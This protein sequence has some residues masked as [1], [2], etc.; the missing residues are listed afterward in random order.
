MSIYLKRH[1]KI[2]KRILHCIRHKINLYDVIECARCYE[3]P[4]NE[5][6]NARFSYCS[7]PLEICFPFREFFL[8][9]EIYR[10][11]KNILELTPPWVRVFSL[12]IGP[13][14]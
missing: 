14:L 8:A 12:Q 11:C 9:N 3:R 13:E 6:K 10:V 7:S 1:S 2:K 4:L 5:K